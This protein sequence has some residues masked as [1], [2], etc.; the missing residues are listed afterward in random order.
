[1]ILGNVPASIET[2]QALL[3]N[4]SYSEKG[5]MMT[6]MATRMALDLDLPK[7]YHDLTMSALSSRGDHAIA[8]AE[9]GDE[10]FRKARVWFGTFVLEH[11]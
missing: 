3:V 8:A 1:M 4:A 10:L 6:S 7:A 9:S 2:I 5:W 11:M